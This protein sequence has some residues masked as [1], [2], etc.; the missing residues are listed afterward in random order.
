V[1]RLPFINRRRLGAGVLVLAASVGLTVALSS[2]GASSLPACA[3][4]DQ[5]PSAPAPARFADSGGP[6]PDT[7]IQ[8]RSARTGRVLRTIARYGHNFTNNGIAY[9]PDGRYVYITLGPSERSP[10]LRIERIAIATGAQRMIAHGWEPALSPDGRELAYFSFAHRSQTVL[11]M[12][13]VTGRTLR[14]DLKRQLGA[15]QVL[16]EAPPAWFGGGLGFVMAS[17][18]PPVANVGVTGPGTA[19]AGQAPVRFSLITVTVSAAGLHADV[20][21]EPQQ[22]THDLAPVSAGPG[23][24]TVMA[25][26][27]AAGTAA[28]IGE[29][30]FSPTGPRRCQLVTIPNALVLGFDPTG[31]RVI[32]LEGHNPP[33]PIEATIVGDRLE[34]EHRL[35]GWGTGA[36]SW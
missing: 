13:L 34:R 12:N 18:P 32:F 19:H 31:L 16:S 4:A 33:V 11:V 25:T 15:D 7:L 27:L 1:D 29:I 26:G 17:G 24:R 8:L 35:A 3:A 5:S 6:Q 36:L 9:S 14:L 28:A 20:I 21:P 30:T 22:A 23:D 2:S 10:D